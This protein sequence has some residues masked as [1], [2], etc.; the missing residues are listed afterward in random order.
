[1]KKQ[2]AA[3]QNPSAITRIYVED[4]FGKYTYDL[5][6]SGREGNSLSRLVILYGDNGSGKTTILSSA[7]HLLSS[8]ESRGHRTFLA[9]VPF[10]V[11]SVYL[12]N[13]FGLTAARHIQTV[14]SYTLSISKKGKVL[15]EVYMPVDEENSVTELGESE[16]AY[17]EFCRLLTELKITVYSLSDKR[18]FQSDILPD[19][20]EEEMVRSQYLRRSRGPTQRTAESKGTPPHDTQDLALEVA[21]SRVVTLIRN[22]ILKGSSI[23]ETNVNQ[24][25]RDIVKRIALSRG[26]ADRSAFLKLEELT[27]TLKG[28]EDRSRSFSQYHLMPPL[29]V[30]ELVGYLGSAPIGRRTIMVNVLSPFIEGMTARLDA[31]Q[32]TLDL[33]TIFV[34]TVNKFLSDKR[35]SFDPWDELRILSTDGQELMP[36]VLS[37]GEKQLLL[38]MCNTVL[39]RERA[40]I[41]L[42]DEPELSLNVKWQRQLVNALLQL[43]GDGNVQFILATHS[44]ELLT[45]HRYNVLKLV[46]TATGREAVV[47]HSPLDH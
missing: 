17:H 41:L 21:L 20:D 31:L 6:C 46:N 1:M 28:I 9:S 33:I 24:I 38:L 4:L 14:G 16:P 44:I 36:R 12:A 47:R 3:N 23:G 18:R 26:P 35:I 27:N 30:E 2:I 22:Q 39:A 45:H 13:G 42:I 7:F 32:E 15:A 43:V 29:D 10:R 11:F 40:S 8:A 25:Y 5:D 34:E 19:A 37:S